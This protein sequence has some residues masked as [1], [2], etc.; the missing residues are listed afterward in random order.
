M[1]GV[2]F[3]SLP[4]A[5]YRII[6]LPVAGFEIFAFVVGIVW[7]I[8]PFSVINSLAKQRRANREIVRLLQDMNKQLESANKMHGDLNRAV[9]WFVDREAERSSK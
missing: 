6:Q 7:L 1:L 8:F 3:V 2:G 4:D 5:R 9:Q